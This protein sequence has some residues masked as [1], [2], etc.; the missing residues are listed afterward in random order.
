MDQ[1]TMIILACTGILAFGV[2]AVWVAH[3]QERRDK[4]QDQ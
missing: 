3:W 2:F 1:N 4:N